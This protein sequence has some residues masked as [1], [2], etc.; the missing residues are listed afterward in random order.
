MSASV[1]ADLIEAGRAAV[2]GGR[3]ES[4][5]SWVNAALR[6][7]ADHDRRLLALD[8]FL[9]RYEAEHGEIT[10]ADIEDATRWA[11]NQTIVVP[12]N[13]QDVA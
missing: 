13:G 2:A 10:D 8:E 1:D 4:F 7:Q 9:A 11:R 12:A 5:S 3:A 6:R